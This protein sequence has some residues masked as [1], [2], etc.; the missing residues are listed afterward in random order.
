MSFIPEAETRD[1]EALAQS[2]K[3]ADRRKRM[4]DY[5]QGIFDEKGSAWAIL[6]LEE[7]T[8]DLRQALAC[9]DAE[10]DELIERILK[11]ERQGR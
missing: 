6:N 1:E 7:Q 10:I 8:G 3:D 2:A 5:L 4:N 11:V 9:Q